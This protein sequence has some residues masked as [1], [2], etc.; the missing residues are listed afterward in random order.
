MNM[1]LV[2][3][4][5]HL[6]PDHALTLIDFLDQLQSTLWN[7]YGDAIQR[8]LRATTHTDHSTQDFD[9]SVSF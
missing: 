5:L 1:K 9:D 4:P 7:H 3:L 2:Q 8:D 6:S